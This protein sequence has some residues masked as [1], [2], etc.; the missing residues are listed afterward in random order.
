MMCDTSLVHTANAADGP[1][2]TCVNQKSDKVMD[3]L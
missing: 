1:L 2:L 3:A